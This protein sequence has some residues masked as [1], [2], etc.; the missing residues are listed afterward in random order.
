MKLTE[1]ERDWLSLLVE[2]KIK[3]DKE[4]LR[5]HLGS[6]MREWHEDSLKWAEGLLK[7]LEEA[8]VIH[9]PETS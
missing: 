2:D 5:C 9:E 8:E 6:N 3:K 4:R 7:K 1:E